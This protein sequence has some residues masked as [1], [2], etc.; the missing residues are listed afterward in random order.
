MGSR[1]RGPRGQAPLEDGSEV[2]PTVSTP[3]STHTSHPESTHT[4]CPVGESWLHPVTPISAP[5]SRDFPVH[6]APQLTF[7]K[8]PTGARHGGLERDW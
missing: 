2:C 5:E 7:S 6:P 8:E 1:Q 3:K 4:A